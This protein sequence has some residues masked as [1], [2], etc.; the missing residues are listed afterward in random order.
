MANFVVRAR[1][2]ISGMRVIFVPAQSGL[3]VPNTC[4]VQNGDSVTWELQD[5][6]GSPLT[7]VP[8]GITIRFISFPAPQT[9]LLA[10]G[11]PISAPGRT[12]RSD[13]NSFSTGGLYLYV[14]EF[15]GTPL[16]CQWIDV[17]PNGNPTGTLIDSV[18]AGVP[19]SPP[20][21]N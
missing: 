18:G 15:N 10:A 4:V 6:G 2:D 7:S 20:P 21:P 8:A 17:D 3:K 11:N 14:F 19:K 1:I 9:P 13:V 12:V 16:R 5:L